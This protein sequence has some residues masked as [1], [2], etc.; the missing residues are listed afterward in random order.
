MS[1]IGLLPENPE[2]P[3]AFNA[4]EMSANGRTKERN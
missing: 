4:A 3:L 1:C 2:I